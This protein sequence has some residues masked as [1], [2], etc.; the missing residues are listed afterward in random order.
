M[1]PGSMG[2]ESNPLSVRGLLIS[3]SITAVGLILSVVIRETGI[4]VRF[5]LAAAV[6]FSL[7][8]ALVMDLFSQRDWM[9]TGA[10]GILMLL[11]S[12]PLL[13][14]TVKTAW[15]RENPLTFGVLILIAGYFRPKFKT[16]WPI[17]AI[18]LI[19]GAAHILISFI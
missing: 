4:P 17:F 5:A 8:G 15:I 14:V 16:S 12:L 3:A 19:L 6:L 1:E 18:A 13:W 10:M 2:A 11:G 9:V 7:I